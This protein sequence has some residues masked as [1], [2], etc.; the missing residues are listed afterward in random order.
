MPLWRLPALIFKGYNE[1]IPPPAT[2]AYVSDVA[3][4]AETNRVYIASP[5]MDAVLP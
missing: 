5:Y 1:S 3:V 4:N 2:G